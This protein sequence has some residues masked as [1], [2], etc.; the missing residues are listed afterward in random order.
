MD[1]NLIPPYGGT[2][3]NLCASLERRDQARFQAMFDEVRAFFGPFTD[4]AM[5][6]SSYL[7]DRIVEHM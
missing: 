6:Q 1:G 2:L 4:E 7:I 5:Q 3:V